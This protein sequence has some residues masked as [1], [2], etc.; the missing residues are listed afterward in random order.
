[1]DLEC[2]VTKEELKRAVWDCGV[3]KS[4]GPDGFSFGFYLHFWSSTE[5][6]MFSAVR[7]FFTFVDIPKGFNSSFIALIP[8]IP[9]A[10]L[11]KDFRPISLIGSIYKIIAKILS[12][13]LVMVLGDIVSEVQS[14]FIAG[15]QILDGPFILSEVLQWCKSKKKQ[16]LIFKVDFEKAFDSV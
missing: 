13:R 10:N 8:K 6:D 1:M 5:N 4:S 12:N 9:N 11:V 15:R 3:D 7:H 14:A 16:S 2:E